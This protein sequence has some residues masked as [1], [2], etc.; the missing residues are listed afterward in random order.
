MVAGEIGEDGHIELDACGAALVERV[1]RDFGDELGGS[2]LRAFG[3]QFKQI[4]RLGGG[5]ERGS[6]FAGNVVLDG[7]D[8]DCFAA[9]M[10]RSDSIR[11]AVVVL[12][13]VPVMPVAASFFSGW[14]KNAAEA[15]ARA[16]R[17]CSTSRTGISGL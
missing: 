4:S 2:A 1:A 14:P 17:P 16:R 9:A 5:V 6:D 10:L 7:A 15:S 13:L 3:H 11:K 8:E 12:P